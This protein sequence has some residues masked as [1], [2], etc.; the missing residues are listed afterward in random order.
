[1]LPE[2]CPAAVPEETLELELVVVP[3]VELFTL[4]VT[5]PTP[6]TPLIVAVPLT[7]TRKP[8][9]RRTFPKG[10]IKLL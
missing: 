5:V 6:T 7:N 9:V 1:M 8:F 10:T 4:P 3:L 2:V